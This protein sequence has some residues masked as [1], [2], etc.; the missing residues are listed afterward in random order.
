MT[1]EELISALSSLPS[2]AL[3]RVNTIETPTGGKPL[4]PLDRS[5][6]GE[7]VAQAPVQSVGMLGDVCWIEAETP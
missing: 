5:H 2:N 6:D 7:R 3:V 4:P 1:V